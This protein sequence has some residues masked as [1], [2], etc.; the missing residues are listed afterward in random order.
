MQPHAMFS[1]LLH[2]PMYFWMCGL[3]VILAY[4]FLN[5][6]HVRYTSICISECVACT[7]VCML[8]GI[9]TKNADT[10]HIW[11]LILY[12]KGTHI[13]HAC[14]KISVRNFHACISFLE[15]ISH[16][17]TKT[18]NF[19]KGACYRGGYIR[20]CKY[21]Y[22][23]MANKKLCP[24]LWPHQ[25]PH[26]VPLDSFWTQYLFILDPFFL[27]IRS[28]LISHNIQA[29]AQAAAR[30]G[31]SQLGTIEQGSYVAL[32]MFSRSLRFLLLL[33]LS[34]SL[35]HTTTHWLIAIQ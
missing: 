10:R 6:W 33:L 14:V 19:H 29:C 32:F 2:F 25:G 9:Y 11:L 28:S 5:V 8:A 17:P 20:T 7:S 4:V 34:L 21:K 30:S 23:I 12:S 1:C 27:D 24:M 31:S 15:F 18:Y 35:T 22:V 13:M 26:V 16:I 3:Y